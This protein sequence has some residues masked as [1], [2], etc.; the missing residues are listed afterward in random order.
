MLCMN[1]IYAKLIIEFIILI[2]SVILAVVTYKKSRAAFFTSLIVALGTC[3]LSFIIN[4]SDIPTPYINRESDYSAIVLYT[5]E[6]MNIEYRI[7]TS[8][9]DSDKWITYKEPFKLEK[10]AIIYARAKTLCYTSVEVFK[11]VYVTENG[12]VYFSSAE[13]PGEAVVSIIASYNYEDPVINKKSGNH[14]SGY[15]IKKDDIKVIG[16]DLNGE[17][18][19]ISDFSYS[20]KILKSGKNTIEVEY[21]IADDI[22][23]KSY[24]YVNADS[25]KMINLEAKYTE[26]NA[27]LDT[28]LDNSYFAV[29]GT[30]EDGTKKEI[31]GYSISPVELIEGKNEVTI[32]KD[33]LY[34]VVEITAIDR[35]TIFENESEPNDDIEK[36]NEIDSGIKYSGSL[37]SDEDVDYYKM[38]LRQKGRVSIKFTHTK[39]DKDE[40]F[41]V[42][43]LLS[44]EENNI[45]EM[46]VSGKNAELTSNTVRVSSGFYYIKVSSNYHYSNEKYT[47][48]VL[49][50]EED[51]SYENEPNDN[52]SE[53]AMNIS[54]NKK[55][56]GNLSSKDDIDYYKFSI[57][58]KRKVWIDFLHDKTS[59]SNTL[60]KISLFGD[61]DQTLLEF[62]SSGE[63]AKIT[64]DSLRLP[65]GNYYIRINDY[66]WSN[67]DYT[68]YVH[69]Q[70]EEANSENED[71]GDYS[72]ATKIDLNSSITGNLQSNDDVDFYEFQLN[73]KSNIKVV[74]THSQTDDNSVFWIYELTSADSS[75]ALTNNEDASTVRISGNSTNN[76][77][78]EWTSLPKGKYYLKVYSYYYNNGD[79]KIKI[80][81]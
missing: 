11:D 56:T 51:D 25:P 39:L 77:S 59:E 50:D 2:A 28:I 15:E 71:N 62:D 9:D 49:F 58:E 48:T 60:W 26:T 76:I 22:T 67:I 5:D 41:W 33:G 63:N 18:K 7:S 13:E 23:V 30:Y 68:F 81:N 47:L 20:P 27:Y 61:S 3:V 52:L 74:F 35:N 69:S 73:N 64:S 43:S 38:Y 29:T 14:Y 16:T 12:L 54:L 78:S 45:I 70:K 46:N 6:P 36:A 44:K 31:S 80:S 75:D 17:E 72:S 53:E 37:N 55:Y 32:S 10:S 34:D 65:A 4:N 42:I 57:D 79:Y 19:V 40:T 8:D 21:S 1:S 66:Y 24:I